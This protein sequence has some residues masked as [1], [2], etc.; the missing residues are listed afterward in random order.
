MKALVL[1]A[2]GCKSAFTAGVLKY[3]LCDIGNKY[4]IIC[5]TSSGAIIAAFLGMYKQ[6]DEKNAGLNLEKW[7]LKI[8]NSSIYKHWKFFGPLS[9]LW[10]PCYFDSTPLQNL[11]YKTL[12]LNTIRNSGKIISVGALSLNSS[13]YHTFD[14]THPKFIEATLASCSYP[15]MFLPIKFNSGLNNN[16]EENWTDGGVKNYSP[17][18]TAIDLGATSIDIIHTS[19]ENRNYLE[20]GTL[21]ILSTLRISFDAS[22]DKIMSND[23]SKL[24]MYNELAS[25]GISSKKY[26][27]FQIIRP[28]Y[29]LIAD[30]LDFRPEKIQE[31]MKK[32]YE[33]AKSKYI[34]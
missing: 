22:I 26:I 25:A 19:P 6:D 1:S 31:M 12:N 3:L 27:P 23:L 28:K 15:G 21:N 10:K 13:K 11:L 32:G 16:I 29:N 14:Q 8:D 4:D 33:E 17:C 30:S 18:Q 9:I 20:I 7:W 2:G 34:K 5:G 24:E